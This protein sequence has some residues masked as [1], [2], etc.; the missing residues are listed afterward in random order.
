MPFK[1]MVRASSLG[2]FLKLFFLVSD[3]ILMF[4]KCFNELRMTSDPNHALPFAS[5]SA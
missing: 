4:I 2:I 5:P 1:L 3:R